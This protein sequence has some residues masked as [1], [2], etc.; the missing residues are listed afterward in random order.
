MSNRIKVGAI[1]FGLLAVVAPGRAD[2]ADPR[3]LEAQ[4][5]KLLAA[6]NKDDV[7]AFFQ[8]WAST[9]KSIT[10]D[11]TYDALYKNGAKK[12]YGDYKPKTLKFRKDGSVLTG[13]YLV[14][15]FEAQFSK[16]KEGVIAVNFAKEGNEY[17]FMQVQMQKK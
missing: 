7:K 14:V 8:N 17:K 1:A 16:E 5:E 12:S 11:M 15:Y 4:M 2:D 10:T 6:Y 13:D 9:V 3:K